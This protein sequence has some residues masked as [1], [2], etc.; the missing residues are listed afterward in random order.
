M[1]DVTD[2]QKVGWKE[3]KARRGTFEQKLRVSLM[4]V[5]NTAARLS[6]LERC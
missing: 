3:V 2:P 5:D 6:W 4:H 1:S